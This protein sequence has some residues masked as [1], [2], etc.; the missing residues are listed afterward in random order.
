M[1]TRDN[2]ENAFQIAK[3]QYTDLGIDVETALS[4]VNTIPISMHCWQGDDV[5]GF[6]NPQGALTGGIQTTGNY[7]GKARTPN[8][9]RTD[10]S[11]AMTMIPGELR[12]NL[13]Q[14]SQQHQASDLDHL[15]R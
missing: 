4:T 3:Q 1:N 9:L 5:A 12:L 10:I 7:P 11:E 14:Q 15:G 6:E 2:I 8:E 13:H